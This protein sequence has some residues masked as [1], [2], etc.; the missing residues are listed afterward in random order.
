VQFVQLARKLRIQSGSKIGNKQ[1]LR[2]LKGYLP[3]LNQIL[4]HFHPMRF[5]GGLRKLIVT[6]VHCLKQL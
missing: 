3:T 2:L 4:V 5:A 1:N 6:K